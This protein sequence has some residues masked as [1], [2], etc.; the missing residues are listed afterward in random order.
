M[1]FRP[2]N[3]GKKIKCQKCGHEN[4]AAV[5]KCIKCKEPL[6]KSQAK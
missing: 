2:A 3:A 1:C 4:P 6:K 5:Q